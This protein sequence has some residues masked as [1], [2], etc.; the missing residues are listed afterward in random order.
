[1]HRLGIFRGCLLDVRNPYDHTRCGAEARVDTADYL[2]AKMWKCR[3]L[4]IASNDNLTTY[5]LLAL[6]AEYEAKAK[7]A[8]AEAGAVNRQTNLPSP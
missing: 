1:M 8:E 2:W 7:V 3:R 4:A 6:A 5:R